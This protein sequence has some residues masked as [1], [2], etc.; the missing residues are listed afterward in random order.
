MFSLFGSRAATREVPALY[1][2]I[3]ERA[4]HPVFFADWGVPDTVFGRFEMVALHVFLVLRRLK[5]GSAR[6][7]ALAQRLFDVFFADVDRSLREL[8]VGDLSVPKKV[9]GL[10]KGFYGR[11]VAYDK[12]MD[13]G[14]RAALAA[15]LDRNVGDPAAERPLDAARLAAYAVAQDAALSG[16]P[17]ERIAAGDPGFADP[18]ELAGL[19]ADAQTPAPGDRVAAAS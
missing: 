3:V 10:A 14:D 17:V 6:E 12:A 9:K 1:G 16:H 8:G 11:I 15:A 7:E 13:A 2:A 5:A 4:R 18:A 19:V